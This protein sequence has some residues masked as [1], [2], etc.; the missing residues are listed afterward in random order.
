MEKTDI[1]YNRRKDLELILEK[2]KKFIEEIQFGDLIFKRQDGKIVYS[3]MTE[4]T[5]H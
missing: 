2:A 3:E 1:S 5:K 4:K